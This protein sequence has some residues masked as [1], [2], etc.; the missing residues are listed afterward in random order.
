MVCESNWGIRFSYLYLRVRAGLCF[1]YSFAPVFRL[2]SNIPAISR[3]IPR[4]IPSPTNR[5]TLVWPSGVDGLAGVTV[6]AAA[7]AVAGTA[8]ADGFK[9]K[10]LEVF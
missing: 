8:Q 9:T 3:A 7:G 1:F 6:L 10:S 2:A 4:T 5:N